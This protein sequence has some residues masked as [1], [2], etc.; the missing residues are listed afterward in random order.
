MALFKKNTTVDTPFD[1]YKERQEEQNRLLVDH[2]PE[3][4]IYMSQEAVFF[5][6]SIVMSIFHNALDVKSCLIWSAITVVVIGIWSFTVRF[7]APKKNM[8]GNVIINT[9]YILLMNIGI[10]I[11]MSYLFKMEFKPFDVIALVP[12]AL[13]LSIVSHGFQTEDYFDYKEDVLWPTLRSIITILLISAICDFLEVK[14]SFVVIILEG[15]AILAMS[16]FLSVINKREFLFSPVPAYSIFRSVP[17]RNPYAFVRFF[18]YRAILLFVLLVAGVACIVLC[19]IGDMYEFKLSAFTPIVVAI[20]LAIYIAIVDMIPFFKSERKSTSRVA[21][22]MK[23]YEYPLIC[24][25]M[26]FPFI[27]EYSI[28]K[29]VV[30]IIFLVGL[31]I[32]FSSFVISIPRR[33]L[34]TRRVKV[35]SGVPAILIALGLLD[36]VMELLFMIY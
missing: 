14:Q 5:M 8:L 22:Y 19:K 15:I 35:A 17:N 28:L 30:Y 24:A 12:L 32:M 7:I 29:T 3:S 31:D 2:I 18:I 26:A 13:G 21:R 4:P 36:M 20:V 1:N 27:N 11:G 34:F 25:F 10:V 23:Y 6:V 9:V 16:K 33:L